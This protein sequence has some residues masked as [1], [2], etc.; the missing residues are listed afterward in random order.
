MPKPSQTF[1]WGPEICSH[2][3]PNTRR[4]TPDTQFL[5]NPH[6]S[7]A[8]EMLT[9]CNNMKIWS[10]ETKSQTGSDA[11]EH[12]ARLIADAIRANGHANIIV[13]TGASQ[14]EVLEALAASREVNW[15][16]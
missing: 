11:G 10:R 7:G 16:A 4:P 6:Q 13:A 2:P 14:F 1:G 8:N 3:F 15:S 12:G 9:A 5:P